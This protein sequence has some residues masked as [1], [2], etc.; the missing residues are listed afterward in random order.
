MRTW[1]TFLSEQVT[2]AIDGVALLAIVVGTAEAVLAI[3]SQ[4]FQRSPRRTP[5]SVW[6]RYSRWLVAALTFQLAADIIQT[7]ISS[8]WDAIGRVAAIAAVRTV[9]DFFLDRDIGSARLLPEREKPRGPLSDDTPQH[10]SPGFEAD[11]RNRS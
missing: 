11:Y 9:L 7:A 8:S 6:M 1:L 3:G 4:L 10:S 5:R 2:L